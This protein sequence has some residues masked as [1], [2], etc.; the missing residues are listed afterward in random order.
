MKI[1]Y[2]WLLR[3][4]PLGLKGW[5]ST[6]NAEEIARILTSVGL[7]VEQLSS[8]SSIPGGL[9]GLVVGEVEAVWKHPQADKLQLT[10]VHIGNEQSLQIVC[11]APNVAVGQK[12]VVALPGTTLHPVVGEPFQLKKTKIPRGRKRRHALCCR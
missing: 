9:E 4:L 6:L 11:G 3:Y 10:R 12:V 7:E 8:F 1:A 2:R 5:P